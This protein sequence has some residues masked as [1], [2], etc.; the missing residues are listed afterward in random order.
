[1][2]SNLTKHLRIHVKVFSHHPSI[3]HQSIS[4]TSSDELSTRAPMN[5]TKTHRCSTCGKT[6]SRAQNLARHKLTHTGLLPYRCCVC[7]RAFADPSNLAVHMRTHTGERPY[8]C[9]ICP[10]SFG[11][12]GNLTTHM[13]SHTSDRPY[14]CSV[15]WAGFTTFGNLGAHERTHVGM[16]HGHCLVCQRAF[17]TTGGLSRHM[18]IHRDEKP[19]KY[20]GGSTL[21][22]G[23]LTQQVIL[24]LAG[25]LTLASSRRLGA[26]K[27]R[28]ES[29]WDIIHHEYHGPPA[30][31]SKDGRVVDTQEVA[32]AKANHL[33]IHAETVSELARLMAEA[34]ALDAQFGKKDQE[35]QPK[36]QEEAQ[37]SKAQAEEPVGTGGEAAQPEA[38]IVA[39]PVEMTPELMAMLTAAAAAEEQAQQQQAEEAPASEAAPVVEAAPEAAPVAEVEAP[40]VQE[41]P[42]AQEQPAGEAVVGEKPVAEEPAKPAEEKPVV[43]A[44][45]D[46]E[47]D[48]ER[49]ITVPQR[50]YEG[51]LA[52]LSEDGRVVDTIEV[53]KAKEAHL[54]AYEQAVK[55]AK[56]SKDESESSE[57]SPAWYEQRKKIFVPPVYLLYHHDGPIGYNGPK[58]PLGEDGRVKDTQE[59]ERA[60]SEHRRAYEHAES[61][62]KR[63]PPKPE[64]NTV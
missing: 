45:A 42:A 64:D 4:S 34:N 17:A 16:I 61:V 23:K 55:L 14:S 50:N 27:H 48:A 33:S 60:K 5:K 52:P 2:A 18:V 13:R 63:H 38:P 25:L 40:S 12:S 32:E 24:S 15:C 6:F 29:K 1:M 53:R 36:A 59:V 26:V 10:K 31:L 39:A 46:N 51:P 7:Q 8:G 3:E 47:V 43:E 20:L 49:P 41:A 58:A 56:M 57:S 54:I 37:Q 44:E 30:P 62:A 19:H 22:H 28:R 11:A 21:H 35:E 9:S